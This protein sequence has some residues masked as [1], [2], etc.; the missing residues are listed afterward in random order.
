MGKSDGGGDGSV[1][2][3]ASEIGLHQKRA[4]GCDRSVSSTSKISKALYVYIFLSG[5]ALH[6]KEQSVSD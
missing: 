2:A 4:E 5:E 6:L 1:K 3:T